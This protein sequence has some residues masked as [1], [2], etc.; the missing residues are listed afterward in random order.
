MICLLYW[1]IVNVLDLIHLLVVL[2]APKA[3]HQ[4]AQAPDICDCSCSCTVL[5]ASSHSA[6]YC[7]GLDMGNIFHVRGASRLT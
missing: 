6:S 5:R 4:R 2:G 3:I 1:L 7:V